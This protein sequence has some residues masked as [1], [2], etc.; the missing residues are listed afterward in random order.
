MV[1]GHMAT[2]EL[3]YVGDLKANHSAETDMF[4]MVSLLV[5]VLLAL[6]FQLI[7]VNRLT[8]HFH[9]ISIMVSR[10]ILPSYDS[11]ILTCH[12]SRSGPETELLTDCWEGEKLEQR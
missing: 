6:W 1:N 3:I 11:A 10:L 2:P 8:I 12:S 9:T 4:C 7:M 5:F